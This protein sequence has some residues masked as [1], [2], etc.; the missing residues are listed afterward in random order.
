MHDSTRTALA[1]LALCLANGCGDNAAS[2][3]AGPA[4]GGSA[5][6]SSPAP[7]DVAG[8]AGDVGLGG[9]AG[10]LPNP[11]VGGSASTTVV[12]C[13]PPIEK[14][15]FVEVAATDPNIRYV[16]RI[17]RKTKSVAFAYPAVQIQARF[18]GDALDMRLNDNGLDIAPSTNY[19]WIV[20]D[21]VASK[22]QPCQES[23]VYPLARNL[24]PGEHTISIIKRTE[25]GPGG[26]SSA[27]L[28]EFL[29]F[30]VRTGTSLKPTT[31]PG[32]LLEFVGDSITCG[33]GNELSTDDPSSY[34][35]TSVNEDAW[36]AFGAVTAQWLKADYVAIAASGRGVMRNWGGFVSLYVPDLYEMTLPEN[37]SLP[38]WDH[39]QYTPDAIVINLGTND[40]SPGVPLDEWELHRANFRA[41][42]VAFLRRI[43]A[44]HPSSA[45]VVT[46]GPMMNDDSPAGYNAWTAILADVKA[47][48]ETR[49]AEADANVFFLAFE[50]QTGPYGEDWHPT[51]ATHR[52]MAG[53]LTPFLSNLLGWTSQ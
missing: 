49:Q 27:G 16:G 15:G 45:I 36:H 13:A 40:Y 18:E 48:M 21:G 11:S 39:S 19:Y 38:P 35:F 52:A 41:A 1:C 3:A 4:L 46:V 42:Y 24:G 22:L 6:A 17:Q 12:G 2:K 31:A 20:V 7:L 26:H 34:K 30:R 28:G 33:Y 23:Q 8:S 43:R 44:V 9:A 37:N 50:P 47:V 25:S 14:D 51:L 53:V 32:R 5:G 10:A 29:G